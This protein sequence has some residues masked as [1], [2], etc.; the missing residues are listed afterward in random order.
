MPVSGLVTVIV[1]APVVAVAVTEITASISP[2][3]TKLS[4]GDPGAKLQLRSIDE[5]GA[6]D[7]HGLVGSAA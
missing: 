7:V 2:A 6:E 3:F 1:R 4:D 5:V